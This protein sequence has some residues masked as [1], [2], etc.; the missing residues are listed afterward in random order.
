LATTRDKPLF[1]PGPLT[2]SSSVKQAMMH[3]LGSRDEAFVCTVNRVRQSLL[4]LAGVSQASGYEAILMQGSGTF[5]L[6]AVIGSS[7]PHGGKLLVLVN[8]GYGRRIAEIG[9][10]LEIPTAELGYREDTTPDPGDLDRALAEDGA[11]SH[12]AVVHCETTTG[13]LNPIDRIGRA[14]QRHGRSF[15]V[16][17]MSAFGAVPIDFEACGIDYLVSSANKCIEG[18]PG[19]AFVICRRETLVATRGW[20]RSLS[21]DLLS[22]W[23]GL[24]ATGQFR[25]TPPTHAILAFD[26][27]L[28][29]LEAEGGV[30]GRGARYA[31]NHRTLDA[32]MNSL[33]FEPYLAPRDQGYIITAFRYPEHPKFRFEEF[34]RRLSAAGFV[35]YPGVVSD[36]D[37]FRIGTIGQIFESDLRSLLAAI[38]EILGEM[39]IDLLPQAAVNPHP[40]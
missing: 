34:Y 24:E 15:I 10:A 20:A 12:V 38:R 30:K 17:S 23:E 35:I 18:V 39:G 9:R 7:I 36:A 33:G 19:F 13:I 37:T 14:V 3:D 21:L 40:S 25:F 8:G 2:T 31:H 16:D 6:E 1:T 4:A 27:A 11:V 5:G 26:Q 32:G 29:E 22:Q 28:A